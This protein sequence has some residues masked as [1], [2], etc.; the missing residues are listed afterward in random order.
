[1]AITG[2]HIAA[3]R[4][5][6]GISQTQLAEATGVA[7]HTILRFETNQ[8]EPRSA[9]VEVL[10]RYLETRGIEFA[11]SGAPGVRLWPDRVK[12]EG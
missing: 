1:M 11:N 10:R 8:S 3:A 6:L 12:T 9:T 5:L 4:A 2:K 7:A